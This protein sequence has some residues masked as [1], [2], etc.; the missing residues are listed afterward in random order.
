MKLR[1]C[2][3]A[4]AG[5]VAGL[6]LS[7]LSSAGAASVDRAAG[8]VL[9]ISGTAGVETAAGSYRVA[10][11]GDSVFAGETLVTGA[12]GRMQVK[13]VD[14]GL[15]SLRSN[16]RFRIDEFEFEP[17]AGRERSFFSLAKGGFRAVSGRIGKTHADDFRITTP[18]ATLGIR[19]TDFGAIMCVAACAAAFKGVLPGLYARVN[20]GAIV[21]GQAGRELV[22]SAGEVVYVKDAA[23]LPVLLSEPPPEAFWSVADK[24]AAAGLGVSVPAVLGGAAIIAL[25]VAVTSGNSNKDAQQ[26]PE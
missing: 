26:S 12:D 15:I 3:Q 11:G 16:T 4:G 23:S 2:T 13:F 5:L 24:S 1:D 21:I 22:A 6:L 18:V 17:A 9:S 14:N 7:L 19:G 25:P 8:R 10:A 20:Q